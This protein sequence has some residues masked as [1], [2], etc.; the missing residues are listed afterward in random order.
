[1]LFTESGTHPV[2]VIAVDDLP[3]MSAIQIAL[4]QG[5]VEDVSAY[6]LNPQSVARTGVHILQ[7]MSA[8]IISESLLEGTIAEK[9]ASKWCPQDTQIINAALIL[10]ADH[11]LN[12]SSFAARVAAGVDANP[13][14]VVM[15]GLSVLQG[16]KHGK[17][18]ERVA[19]FVREVGEARYA[20]QAIAERLQRGEK[21]SGFGHWLYPDEDPR[22]TALLTLLHQSQHTDPAVMALIDAIMQE[23]QAM[24]GKAP[25][26]DF[27][28]VALEYALRLPRGAALML[29]ALGRTV[30]WI[31][32]A[33][34]QYNA[35]D[36]I[37]PRARYIGRLP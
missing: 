2:L 37:R 5:A 11:E 8:V 4:T 34:E 36:M 14:A 32:H 3:V 13:Y 27:A 9:L 35:G 22:A 23:T 26:I 17:N 21:L 6:S 10:S 20:R 28:L 7:L 30:G 31:A 12:A 15:A 25:N 29:F 18:S 24:I 16:Y 1:A 19:A 33:I